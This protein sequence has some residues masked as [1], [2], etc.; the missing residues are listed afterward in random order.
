MSRLLVR[1]GLQRT[2]LFPA[3]ALVVC[4]L[5]QTVQAQESTD[6]LWLSGL[7]R[8]RTGPKGLGCG[9]AGLFSPAERLLPARRSPSRS[10][11]WDAP[12]C[13]RRLVSGSVG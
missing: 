9:A 5:P 4:I 10:R 3:L 13:L 11:P 1:G 2:A 8:G 6:P 12:P 7:T